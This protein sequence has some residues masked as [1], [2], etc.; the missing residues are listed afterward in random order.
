MSTSLPETALPILA[1][2]T[3]KGT[4]ILLVALAA[5]WDLRRACAA[6][7][8]LLWALTLTG[9]LALPGLSLLLPSWT[10]PVSVPWGAQAKSKPH[11]EFLADSPVAP[12]PITAAKGEQR[13]RADGKPVLVASRE[14][15]SPPALPTAK[16]TATASAAP[17]TVDAAAPTWLFYFW[18][19]G[20]GLALVWI[21]L[22][23][24]SLARL[25]RSCRPLD[26]GG[27]ADM[28][29]ELA[30]G[31]GIRRRLRLRQTGERSIPMTWGVW[32]PVV[33]L[34]EE[35][36]QWP[37]DR[38]RAVL[39]HELA[40][41]RRWD[42]LS[43]LLGHLA[44][45]LFWFHPL[46]WWALSRLRAEQEN[47]CDDMVVRTGVPPA[48]YSEHLL[49]VTASLPARFRVPPLT[50]AMTRSARLRQ[51]LQGLLDPE[52]DRRPLP[53][54]SILLG[55]LAALALTAL[56]AAMVFDSRPAGAAQTAL[57]RPA[58]PIALQVQDPAPK[59][60]AD[61][62]QKL[63]ENYV[64]A[65]DSKTLID[66]A[67]RGM[68]QG[69]KDPYTDYLPAQELG[70]LNTQLRGAMT[71]IGAQLK[72]VDDRLTV[73]SPL[74]G[75]PALK[76]GLR[77]GDAIEAI[78]GKTTRGLTMQQAIQRILG[79]KGTAVKLKIVR[80]DG[81][82][83]GLAITRAELRIPSLGGFRRDADGNW[84]YMVDP[85]HKI[86]YARIYQFSKDTASDLADIVRGLKK[87]GLKGLI[88]DLR[89][90]PGG[91]LE[92]A[93]A[94]CKLFLA[95][96][97]IVTTRRPGKE[98]KVFKADGKDVLGD[99]PLVIVVNE[100]TAS[101]AEIVAGAL[102]DHK[103]AV[104]VGTRTYGKGS[105]QAILKLDDGGALRVTTA[106]H[107]LPSGRNIQKRPGKSTW[108]VDP[109]EGFYVPLPRG[110]SD[111]MVKNAQERAILGAKQE[112]QPKGPAR[113]T[114]KML[115]EQ[116][117]DP[118]LAAAVRT[119]VARL[120]GGEFVPTGKALNLLQEHVQ[121][122]EEMRERRE[123]LVRSLQ[124]LDQDIQELQETTA[125]KKR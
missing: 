39:L 46:A 97:T 50:L 17:I 44:R 109:S 106:Y 123:A 14:L 122:L 29:R 74:E 81:V 70:L 95:E 66:N 26:E 82:V 116:Y 91:L 64:T 3:L 58:L 100:Q 103:R 27:L 61:I 37:E 34:P 23:S 87:D 35:A 11:A 118:Q 67:V 85:D 54:G 94:V 28:A 114:P 25:R 13:D 56:T 68:L 45:A 41:V 73:M 117:A 19:G 121:R 40:H 49:A 21:G 88:L 42:C 113:I 98:E 12:P 51:R 110:Q 59:K 6:R 90:C 16:P 119:L 84:L 75:S 124:K 15:T 53:R 78:D 120:T 2:V 4:V 47:A 38:Q 125:E 93:V 83:E 22:G 105:V 69:L 107:Y 102:R 65:V 32:R 108:G 92:Q 33:L 52:R 115:A 31:V 62:E 101:S 77:P 104:V 48:N 71:G 63:K 80:Q 24:V 112:E 96:G 99:F 55:G 111:A 7:R 60:I 86:A 8:H 79:P 43:Q 1:D 76:A 5:A 89:F 20:T 72:I 30:A 57:A 10:F 18:L 9:L 36:S